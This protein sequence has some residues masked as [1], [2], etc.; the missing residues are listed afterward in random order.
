MPWRLI[1]FI[2]I[3][4]VFLAF[5]SFNLEN[6]CDISFGIK[7]FKDV[8]VFLTIFVSFFLGLLCALPFKLRGGKKRGETLK[9][10]ERETKPAK[11]NFSGSDG[12][13]YGID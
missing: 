1:A 2:I 11:D 3:F 12:G 9:D 5:I 6:R 4:A 8:P 13:D 7:V 10:K